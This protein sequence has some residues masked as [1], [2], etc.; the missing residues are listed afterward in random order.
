MPGTYALIVAAG[1]GHRFGGPLPKQYLPLAGQPLLR[2]TVA[3]FREHP[4]IAGTV[5]V[6]A[7]ADRPLYDRALAPALDDGGPLL[8]PVIGGADRQASVRAGLEALAAFSPDGVLIHDAVRPL[9]SAAVIGRAIGALANHGAA[10]AA[11]PVVDTLKRA[12]DGLA[13][14]T[15]DRAG[16]WR[17]QTP[18]AFRFAPILAA[19]R[20]LEGAGATDDASLAERAG[21]AVALVDGDEDNFKVTTGPDLARAAQVMRSR[22]TATPPIDLRVGTGYDVHRLGP[23][24]SA[25]HV[26]LCGVAVPFDRGL[27]G[28]SDADVGLHTVTDAL[29]G[30]I[31]DGD[32][33]SHFPPS[34]PVWK[35]AESR[36]FLRHAVERVRARRG[37]ILNC[38][39]TLIC[40]R[41]K[42]GPHRDAM[43]AVLAEVLTIGVERVSVKATTTER[44]GFTGREEGIAAQAAVSVLMQ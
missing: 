43:R 33:G 14:Q 42:I 10:I 41:P 25:G 27:I 31:A 44:L 23:A 11:V 19:H 36:Q 18:Q 15:V 34:D 32:I 8:E 1:R 7:E 16:L 9:V 3:A 37:V 28:H 5:V 26:L 20:R 35:G 21:M 24:G 29:F 13:G 39:L 17:A 4:D 2:H 38:D 6:I 22:M 30:A 12:Q 40:E